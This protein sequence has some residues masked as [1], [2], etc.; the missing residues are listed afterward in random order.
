MPIYNLYFVLMTSWIKKYCWGKNEAPIIVLK[1]W[2][3]IPPHHHLSSLGSFSLRI[4]YYH[5]ADPLPYLDDVIFERSLTVESRMTIYNNISQC[6]SFVQ[7]EHLKHKSHL[8][9]LSLSMSLDTSS[10]NVSKCLI[11]LS[12]ISSLTYI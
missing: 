2:S 11:A 8:F 6:C 9:S 3:Y 7:I 10:I 1:L 5:L 4:Q 12:E